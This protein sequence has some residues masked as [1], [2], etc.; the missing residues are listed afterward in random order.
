MHRVCVGGQRVTEFFGYDRTEYRSHRP[1]YAGHADRHLMRLSFLEIRHKSWQ[2]HLFVQRIL[3]RKVV[4][5]LLTEVDRSVL[6]QYRGKVYRIRPVSNAL[7]THT[8]LFGVSHQLVNSAHAELCHYLTQLLGDE[9]HEVHH[10]FRLAAETASQL[11][12]LCCDPDRAGVKIAYPHHDAAHCDQRRGCKAEFLSPEYAG[13]SH[14][15][16]AH[17]LAVGLKPDT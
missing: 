16:P 9:G 14:I 2:K 11:R 17:Q 12:I 6:F 10:I 15:T 3:K 8:Q 7:L 5:V 13:N 1:V 4:H